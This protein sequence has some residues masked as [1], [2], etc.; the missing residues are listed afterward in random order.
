MFPPSG[1]YPFYSVSAQQFQHAA[2]RTCADSLTNQLTVLEQQQGGDAHD[3]ELGGQIGLLVHIDLA[4]LDVGALL[5]HLVHD[6][7]QHPAG[8]APGGLEIEQD[9]LSALQHLGL[10][11]F[12]RD[13]DD[14][15]I[16]SLHKECFFI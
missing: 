2:L 3:A 4:H 6:G 11:V 9:G 5:G 13:G 15:H 8:A 10:K 1:P 16:V 7:A 12:F 14:C